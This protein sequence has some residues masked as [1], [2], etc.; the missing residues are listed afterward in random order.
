MKPV[1]AQGKT[2]TTVESQTLSQGVGVVPLSDT[3]NFPT[4]TLVFVSDNDSDFSNSEYMGKVTVVDTNISVTVE[5]ASLYAHTSA[6]KIWSPTSSVEFPYGC[7]SPYSYI[8]RMGIRKE[9]TISKDVITHRISDSHTL[10]VMPFDNLPNTTFTSLDTFF[11]TVLAHITEDC[12]VAFT[13]YRGGLKKTVRAT[14]LNE[15]LPYTS[16]VKTRASFV[17][18]FQVVTDPGYY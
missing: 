3:S 6:F 10:V 12:T 18:E 14:L 5:Q 17:L 16:G 7:A 11:V 15:E 9:R 4:D 8:N 13:E 2:N 1:L